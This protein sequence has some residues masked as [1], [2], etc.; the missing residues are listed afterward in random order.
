MGESEYIMEAQGMALT[1]RV[2]ELEGQVK[3]LVDLNQ[4][5]DEQRMAAERRA[6][7]AEG[8]VKAI[9]YALNASTTAEQAVALILVAVDGGE[10]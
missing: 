3:H 5:L 10:G 4:R 8:K 6:E 2:G 1:E 7:S 9:R